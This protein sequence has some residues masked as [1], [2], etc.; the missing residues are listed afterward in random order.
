MIF[1]VLVI[2]RGFMKDPADPGPE[3]PGLLILIVQVELDFLGCSTDA[4]RHSAPGRIGLSHN[5]V[6]IMLLQSLLSFLALAPYELLF[7]PSQSYLGGIISYQNMD[8]ASTIPKQKIITAMIDNTAWQVVQGYYC[9]VTVN[10]QCSGLQ[11]QYNDL[12]TYICSQT[13]PSAHAVSQSM[14]KG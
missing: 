8:V 14:E 3:L 4:D 10:H 1:L 2:H 9:S 12:T 11:S 13:H 7:S 6:R 5:K